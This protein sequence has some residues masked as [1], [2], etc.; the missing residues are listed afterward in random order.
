MQTCRALLQ[1][2]PVGPVPQDQPP[3]RYGK[4]RATATHPDVHVQGVGAVG[5]DEGVYR[6]LD[7]HVH[8]WLLVSG[9]G[10]LSDGTGP[11]TAAGSPG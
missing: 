1:A 10:L 5:E 6:G 4:A 3:A 7:A 8:C 11:E 2:R 9:A